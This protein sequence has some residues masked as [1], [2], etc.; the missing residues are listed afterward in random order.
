MQR[1]PHTDYYLTIRRAK[2]SSGKGNR[3]IAQENYNIKWRIEER[4]SVAVDNVR[5]DCIGHTRLTHG[6]LMAR[7]VKK[8]THGNQR[9][10]IKYCTQCRCR[11]TQYPA[12]INTPMRKDG[13]VEKIKVSY[14]DRDIWRNINIMDSCQD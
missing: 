6:H 9:L 10:T 4:E 14:G 3:K 8:T 7:N 12:N 2:N 1:L 11:K 13:E 5:R